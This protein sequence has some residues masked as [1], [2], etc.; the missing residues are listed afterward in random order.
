MDRLVFGDVGYGKTEVA[1]RPRS[2]RSRQGKQVAVLA[3]TTLS[4]QQHHQT[5]AERFRALSDARRGPVSILTPTSREAVIAGL[6]AGE[7]DL[8]IGTHRLL[9]DDIRF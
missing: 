6:G 7:V 9:S 8:V 2:K 3:P 5:F 4:A 1:I